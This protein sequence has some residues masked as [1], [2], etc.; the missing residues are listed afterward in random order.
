MYLLKEKSK[1]DKK[2]IILNIVYLPKLVRIFVSH[3]V[4]C[5]MNSIPLGKIIINK[6]QLN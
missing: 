4:L 6:H 1:M 2:N 5:P 3:Q